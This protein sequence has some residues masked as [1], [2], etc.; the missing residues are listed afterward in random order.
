[1]SE[2]MPF[3]LELA[4]HIYCYCSRQTTNS[5]VLYF[6]ATKK[7]G[8]KQGSLCWHGRIIGSIFSSV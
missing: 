8:V 5:A 6:V 3:S 2:P 4:G 1:L 7:E